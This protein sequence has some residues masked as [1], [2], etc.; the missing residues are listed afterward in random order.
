V[1]A[2]SYLNTNRTVGKIVIHPI[3]WAW[4]INFHGFGFILFWLLESVFVRL[5]SNKSLQ[6]YGLC[7]VMAKEYEI[8]RYI[9]PQLINNHCITLQEYPN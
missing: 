7:T 5:C 4:L 1:E 2:Y 3:P 9:V 8:K 6:R